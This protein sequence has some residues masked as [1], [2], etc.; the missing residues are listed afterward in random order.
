MAGAMM[1]VWRTIALCGA[2]AIWAIGGSVLNAQAP[3]VP[4]SEWTGKRVPVAV[5]AQFPQVDDPRISPDGKLIAAKVRSGGVQVLAILPIGASA[6]PEIIA[7]D[8]AE[9]KDQQGQRQVRAWQW[10]DGNHLLITMT[11]RDNIYGRW[12]DIARYA[13][14]N[15]ATRKVVPLGWDNAIA[16]TRLL[17]ASSEGQPR[18]LIQRFNPRNGTERMFRPEVIE[19]NATTGAYTYAARTNP[20]VENWIADGS[21]VV[22]FGSSSDR[23]TGKVRVLYRPNAQSEYRTILSAKADMYEDLALPSFI[24]RGSDK[25]YAYSR[26]EGHRALY[27]YDLTAMK[28]GKKVFGVAGYD[29]DAAFLNHADTELAG[30]RYTE[31]GAR[32]RFFDPRLRE[33]QSILEG[34]FGKGA[35]QIDSADVARERVVFHTAVPGRAPGYY[36]FD[37]NTGGL[38]L[39]GWR[40][41]AL[42]DTVLNP[43]SAIRYK[44]SDGRDVEAV[45]TMPRHHA[46]K[47]N[48][49]VVVLPHGG[50]WARDSVDWDDYGWAQAIAEL[51]Y[52]VLQPNFRGSSGYGSAWEKAGEGA[53][54]LRM[55]DDLNDGVAYLATTGIADPKRACVMGWSY[56]G[57]AAARAAQRDGE[58]FRCAIAGAG[59]FD[60]RAMVA[61][62]V[63]YLGRYGAKQ[64]LGK[65]ATDLDSISPAKHAAEVS[66]PLLIVHGAKDLRVPVGQARGMVAALKKA[67]KVEGRDFIY[68]EQPQN[69]HNLLREAD[70]LQFLD[71]VQS[72][73]AKHNPV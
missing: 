62:D 8:D 52:V 46:G 73:L 69:T 26:E 30:V 42:K 64:A 58:K 57:Y 10:L 66:I 29:I 6:K 43:V 5:F 63:D 53:W 45:L 59:V 39:L 33:V 47:K 68:L 22:R 71:S 18:V 32:T 14:F 44:A 48:L 54:G 70:R 16:G 3:K 60:L 7:R 21:G 20:L 24:L 15:R 51:G 27:E 61:Y 35:V 12:Y 50:P 17:W 11:Y 23:N 56:G 2:C 37:T 19:V 72:F 31:A 40:N 4:S 67:G 28:R 55:Q 13:V 34:Q 36:V 65:A 25:A 49:P 41:E 9:V 1:Q 38:G